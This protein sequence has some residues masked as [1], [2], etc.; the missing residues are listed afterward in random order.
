MIK[1]RPG[2]PPAYVLL[3]LLLG[4]C[5]PAPPV[6]VVEPS[7]SPVAV[8]E[9][10]IG[11]D[12]DAA[13]TFIPATM[14]VPANTVVTLMFTNTSTQPH[15]LQLPRPV[16]AATKLVVAAG[17]ADTFTFTTPGPGHYPFLCS[18]H[19]GMVGTLQVT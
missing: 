1:T 15:N 8:P 19:P 13:L 11:T 17:T 9:H 7:P 5:A 10:R 14:T 16:S 12:S 6:A 18:L 4:A 2:C 3:A